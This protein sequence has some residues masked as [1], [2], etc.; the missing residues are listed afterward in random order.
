MR[1]IP[2]APLRSLL[3]LETRLSVKSISHDVNFAIFFSRFEDN[4]VSRN[5]LVIADLQDVALLNLLDLD[6]SKDQ[7][8]F[9]TKS[10][11]NGARGLILTFVLALALAL[12]VEFR[13]NVDS[14]D[15][16]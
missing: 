4:A 5:L 8:V 10:V 11:N 13:N 7:F 3:T 1:N 12:K 15:R 16:C 2:L 9:R 14:H 6:S